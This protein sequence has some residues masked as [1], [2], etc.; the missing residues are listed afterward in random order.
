LSIPGKFIIIMTM[1]HILLHDDRPAL[2]RAAAHQASHSLLEC[3]RQRGAATL[4]IATGSS[5]FEVL[6]ELGRIPGIP[7]DVITIFHL[8]EYIGLAPDHPASFRRFLRERFIDILP[9]PPA[10]FHEL[11]GCADAAA[12]CRRL[13]SLVPQ[14]DFD[15]A[16]IGIGE[17]G[18]LAF[19]D[20][21]ADFDAE[22]PYRVVMLD[23]W[24]RQQQVGEG[25]FATLADVPTA[26][27]SMSVRRILASRTIICSVPDRRKAEAVRAAVEGPVT[28]AA[29]A[30]ILQRHPRCFLHL[31]RES[32]SLLENR[33]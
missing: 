6:G 13:A 29:P 27:I 7:W 9:V 4:V 2:G 22:E 3:C 30:S 28:P 5:Q 21:P 11:D 33:P 25:W 24:C 10:A 12:E 8:D 31:D 20:P 23:T 18:H 16:M 17:N 14:A 26:A 15:V 19:N 32:A 1:L